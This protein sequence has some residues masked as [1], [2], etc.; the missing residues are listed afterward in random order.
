M[1][2]PLPG[3]LAGPE[4]AS[5]VV[6]FM[7]KMELSIDAEKDRCGFHDGKRVGDK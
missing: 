1:P 4:L 2:E 5:G 6:F 7:G 3:W